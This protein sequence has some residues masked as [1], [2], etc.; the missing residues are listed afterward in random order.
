MRSWDSYYEPP[1]VDDREWEEDN[2]FD[3]DNDVEHNPD[4]TQ[5]NDFCLQD[6]G[7]HACGFS[8]TITMSCV[9][10]GTYTAYYTCPQCGADGYL[11]KEYAEDGDW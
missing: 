5:C 11:E 6:E 4:G 8:G 10:Q 1:W 9:G 3:C 7:Y 2:D